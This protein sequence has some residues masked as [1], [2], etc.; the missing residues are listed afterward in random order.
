VNVSA[1]LIN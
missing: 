1:E